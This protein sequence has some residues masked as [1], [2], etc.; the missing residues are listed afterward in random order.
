MKRRANAE[1]LIRK[2]DSWRIAVL[3]AGL[4]TVG[5]VAS[6]QGPVHLAFF[7]DS[8]TGNDRQRQ[9][10]MQL[11]RVAAAGKLN[12]VFLLGDNIY[13][14]GEAKYIRPKFL[15][16]YQPLFAKNVSFHA[17]L[18][19]H[20]VKSCDVSATDPLP[21]DAGAYEDCDVKVQLAEPRFGY[22]EGK[23][24]YSITGPGAP[25]L[26]EVFVID[27]NTLA[28]RHYLGEG[29][30]PDRDQLDWLA[31]SL[32]ASN[33]TWKIVAMHNAMHTPDPKTFLGFAGHKPERGLQL[34]LEDLFGEKNVHAVFQGHNHFYARLLPL[35]G[36]RYFVAGGGGKRPYAFKPKPGYVVPNT[37]RGKFNHFVHVRLSET[38]FDFCIVDSQ[39]AIRDS[40]GFRSNGAAAPGYGS[41]CPF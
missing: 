5:V 33:A 18:G 13:N 28:T 36:V 29:L 21:R 14:K 15:D 11:G 31:H 6:A 19:N 30:P 10:S 1:R 32:E 4:W 20:D 9:V 24:Y 23:R 39:G 25:P 8:G 16:V 2:R 26:F 40:G 3:V 37:G 35:N 12:Y 38:S 17:A 22:P 27:T 34:Q 7:G 41:G